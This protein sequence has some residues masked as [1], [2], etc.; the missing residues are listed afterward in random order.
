M[1][2]PQAQGEW[3]RRR[4]RGRRVAAFIAMVLGLA[5]LAASLVGV[6]IQVLPRH[7]TAGQQQQIRAWEVSSRWQELTAG[8]IFPA[9]V[10]YQL[11]AAVLYD[12]VPLSLAAARVGIAAPS[13]CGSGV[14]AAAAA[15][16]RRDGCLAVLRATYADATQTYVMTVG[17]AVL[18]SAAAATSAAHQLSAPQ[19]TSAHEK[20]G[21]DTSA[22]A[23]V[24]AVTFRGT[25]AGL[26]DYSKQVTGTSA[27]GPYLVM[28]AAG[29]T[30]GRPRVRVSQDSY[31]YAEMTSLASG[32]AQSVAST[33][34]ATPPPP[35][36]PGSPGC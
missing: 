16:L 23:G 2:D 8:Q 33:L 22:A 28:Y 1:A 14:T 17:V 5:G 36:C 34:A 27:E 21:T 9:S 7:F 6:A 24:L 18:P 19:L 25:A 20:G 31:S 26:Y 4:G 15:V 11:P 13:G 32:V 12:T 3:P 35:H 10:T 30:D 29:Y